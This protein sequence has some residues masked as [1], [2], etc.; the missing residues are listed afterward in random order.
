MVNSVSLLSQSVDPLLDLIQSELHPQVSLVSIRPYDPIAVRHVPMPWQ[1]LG[2]G[3][4]AAVFAH[5]DYPDL[6]VKIY[7]PNRP[8]FEDEVE[9]YRRIGCHPAFSQ[10]FYAKDNLLVLKRLHGITLFNCLHRGLRIPKQVILDID[11][12]LDYARSRGLR[13][14]D[15]HGKNVMMHHGRG[16]VVDISDFLRPGSGSAWHDLKLF[17]YWLYRP[18][19]SPLKVSVP[20]FL[21]DA[22]R[23][24]YRWVRVLLKRK[25]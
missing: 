2:T 13:P 11:Q 20:L 3:N 16:L 5:P 15:V 9:V 17:Y 18:I 21:L 14:H 12:A 10:C 1:L 25:A 6:V 24:L 23:G 7:A 8:G 4:Y 19:I 22:T